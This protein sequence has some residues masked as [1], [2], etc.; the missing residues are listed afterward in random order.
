V[1]YGR[2][3]ECAAIDR[4]LEDARRSRSGALLLRGEP[5]AGKTALLTYATERSPDM[6]VLRGVGVEPESELPFASLHQILRPVL[7]HSGAIPELQQT[8]LRGALG[9][10]PAQGHDRFLVALAVLSLLSE[11]AEERPLLC[12]VDDTHWLDPASADALLFV[13]RRLEAEGIALLLASSDTGGVALR[14][15]D[16]P[17]LAVAGL[18]AD[19]SDAL[20]LERLGSLPAP[21]VRQALAELTRGNPLALIE[22]SSALTAGQLRGR[23]PLPEHPR[24]GLTLERVYQ[25]RI[26]RLP[27]PTQTLLLVAAAEGSGDLGL[28]LRAAARLGIDPESFEPAE[29]A[30]LVRV[31]EGGIAFR[32]PLVRSVVYQGAPFGRRQAAHRALADALADDPDADRRT[33][34]RSAAAVGPD[35][36]V[37]GELE[38][39]AERARLR[40]GLAAAA[41][42][43]ERAADLSSAPVDAGRRLA[44]A[45]AGAWMAGQAERARALLERAVPLGSEP[46]TRA[47]LDHLRGQLQLGSGN[48]EVAYEVLLSGAE[49][50]AAVD[51]GRAARMLSEAGVAA[52][53]EADVPKLIEVG[54]RME[55]LQLP[56]KG[57]QAFPAKVIIGLGRLLQGDAAA[58]VLLIRAAVAQ[59]DR[60]DPEQLRVA[61]GVSLF[62]GADRAA[63]EMLIRA[64]AR[65]RTLGAV[66]TLP[67]ILA[68]FAPLEMWQGDYPAA[69]AHAT[70]GLR[71][72]RETGQEHLAAQFLAALAWIAAVQGRTRDCVALAGAVLEPGT[73]RPLRSSLA[74]TSWA[75]ALS[76]IGAGGW[77]QAIA[78]LEELTVPQSPQSHPQVARLAAADLVEAAHRAGRLDL[79]Q[80]TLARFETF[81]R[82]TAAPW[83]L[84]LLLRCRALLSGGAAAE[85]VFQEALQ[86]HAHGGRPFDEARTRL[87]YGEL[88]RRARRRTEAR[89]QLRGA[90]EIFE[91]LGAAPWG[92]R[93]TAELRATGETARKRQPSALAQLTPQQLQIVRLVAEGATNKEAAAQLFLSPRTVDYHLRNVFV[94]LGISSR[95][96]LIRHAGVQE[97]TSTLR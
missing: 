48:R 3:T 93:A 29:T 87:L 85:R 50:V 89:T 65:A 73:V 92:R 59:A 33:W 2:E 10:A 75:L 22:L 36:E 82:P 72:A 96:E 47:D 15:S 53:G 24:V 97:P 91:R 86:Q 32:Y 27:A 51:A 74:I 88:L 20:L 60:D 71:L 63:H 28:V 81:A 45:A 14:R 44:A 70:E 35:D 37:A 69:M 94:K 40:G 26:S 34:H 80:T 55:A 30:G 6:R 54:R 43:L 56:E 67:R 79:A 49:A 77:Q 25:T 42:A 1:L 13:A 12:V 16:L 83:T 84:A 23:E 46:R 31:D 66:A 68:T 9:L 64:T 78:R 5:G 62:T 95:A 4:L 11:L 90:L 52:W 8:A 39:S 19:A 61:G 76:D 21:N 18:D 57:P 7:G 41:V 17:E 58:A 38:R